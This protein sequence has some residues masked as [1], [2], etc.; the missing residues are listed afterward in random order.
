L[1][2]AKSKKQK[3]VIT[4]TQIY[5]I[6]IKEPRYNFLQNNIISKKHH[7]ALLQSINLWAVVLYHHITRYP[8]KLTHIYNLPQNSC[9][10][11]LCKS[12]NTGI[13]VGNNDERYLQEDPT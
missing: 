13:G 4:D 9:H 8:Y 6:F 12:A 7:N 5:N 10:W 2:K 1:E 11:P 3:E